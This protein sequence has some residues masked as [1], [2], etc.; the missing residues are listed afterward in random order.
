MDGKGRV[1]TNTKSQNSMFH[2]EMIKNAS[3]NVAQ[4]KKYKEVLGDSMVSHAEFGR[5]KYNDAEKWELMQGYVKAVEKG[6]VHALVG[7]RVYEEIAMN[8][9]DTRCYK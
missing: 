8:N 4:Y 5:I 7:F 6:D 9:G 1:A 2:P 3:K